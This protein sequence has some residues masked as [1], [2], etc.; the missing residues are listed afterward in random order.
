LR[1]Q[2]ERWRSDV[3]P[4]AVGFLGSTGGIADD[5]TAIVFARFEDAT[6]AKANGDRPEQTAWWNE[7]AKYYD[8]EPTFRDSSDVTVILD[9][10]SND[11]GFVQVME[12]TVSDRAKADSFEVEMLQELRA[13][14]PDV[15]GG[16]RVWFDS[17]K[18]AQTVYFS[19]EEAARSGESSAEFA[20]PQKEFMAL[21]RELTFLDLHAPMID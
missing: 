9:G 3:K 12:G 10:G 4:G 7:M 19:S 13:A 16:L 20:G 6:A 18:F 11:A 15:M 1:R 8:G 14:R 5:G 17:D 2:L 21:H